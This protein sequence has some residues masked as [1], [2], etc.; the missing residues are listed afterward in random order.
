[1]PEPDGIKTCAVLRA[2]GKT[3]AIPI[4][5]ATAF[6]ESVAEALHAGVDDFVTKPFRVADVMAR[7]RAML[8]VRHLED[9]SERIKAYLKELN[10]PS[11]PGR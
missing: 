2:N 5:L 10:N 4:I 7:V 3:R 6:K 9:K 1:M 8:R 11:P